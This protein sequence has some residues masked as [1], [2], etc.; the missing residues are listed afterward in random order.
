MF[1][2]N[3]DLK[4]RSDAGPTL[5]KAFGEVFRPA[6]SSQPG[7]EHI[8]LLHS[9]KNQ[10]E[11]R[12]GIAFQDETSQKRWVATDLHQEVWPKIETN[13]SSFSVESFHTV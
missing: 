5:E 6:I 4:V 10:D 8:L 11:Y 13:C 9:G 3:V 7:F 12:L 1:V 2:L